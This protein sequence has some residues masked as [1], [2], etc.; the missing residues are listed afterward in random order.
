[1]YKLTNDLIGKKLN[2]PFVTMLGVPTSTGLF[3][4]SIV[5]GLLTYIYLRTFSV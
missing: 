1:M 4:H 2:T 5:F 3:V